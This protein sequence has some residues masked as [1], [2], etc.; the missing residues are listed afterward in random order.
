MQSVEQKG[1]GVVSPELSDI[2][3]EEAGAD[4]AMVISLGSR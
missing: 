2:T 1:Y 4:P 3:M